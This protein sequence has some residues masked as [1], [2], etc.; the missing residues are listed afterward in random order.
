MAKPTEKQ[1]EIVDFY[2]NQ[3]KCLKDT[4]DLSSPTHRGDIEEAISELDLS[5]KEK[6]SLMKSMMTIL[7]FVRSV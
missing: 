7:V 6:E 5:P 2:L 3:I 4:N 1:A